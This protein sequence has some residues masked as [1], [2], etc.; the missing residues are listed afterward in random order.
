MDYVHAAETA[1]KE[2]QVKKETV[3]TAKQLSNKPDT[4]VKIEKA[5]IKNSEFG[6]V[7]EAVQPPY[8]VFLTKGELHL[9]NISNQFTEGTGVVKIK[10]AFMGTGNTLISGTFRP[11]AKSPDFDLNIKIE[12]TQM[13]AMNNLLRAYGNFDVTE[14]LFSVYSELSVKN[15]VVQVYIKPLFKNMKVYDARRDKEKRRFHNL[16]V[17]LSGV[18]H[19]LQH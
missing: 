15:G 8:G 9:N 5:V 1:T 19:S 11:E 13:R 4:L 2:T 7:N 12:K 10:G 6:L 14:G 16:Y 3:K 18:I 17:G